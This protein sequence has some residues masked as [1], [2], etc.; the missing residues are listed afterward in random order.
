MVPSSQG[1]VA[2]QSLICYRTALPGVN[3]APFSLAVAPSPG[4]VGSAPGAENNMSGILA[5]MNVARSGST[6]FTGTPEPTSGDI[7]ESTLN[8]SKRGHSGIVLCSP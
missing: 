5:S 3:A 6:G 7:C 8:S 4:G 2:G 1:Q